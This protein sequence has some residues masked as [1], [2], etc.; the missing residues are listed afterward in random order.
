MKKD[1]IFLMPILLVDD[2]NA[3]TI[4]LKAILNNEGFD[5]ISVAS[6]VEET[7]AF[8]DEYKIDLILISTILSKGSGIELCHE[9]NGDL[10]YEDIPAIMVTADSKIETLRK[11]FENGA[12]DYIAKPINSVELIARVQAHLIRKQVL[13]ERKKSAI[14]DVLT[15]LYNRRYFDTIFDR[16]Y[17]KSKLENIPLVFFMID[18]DNFKK[19]NDNYGH[20]AGDDALQQVSHAMKAQLKRNGDYIFRLGGEEFAIL[21]LSDNI[22]HCQ[23]LSD[24]LHKG[25]YDL[26]IEHKYN[27]KHGR[28]SVSIGISKVDVSDLITKFDIYNT[29]DEALYHAK[30]SGR[31]HSEFINI[32]P[33][34]TK[35][36]KSKDGKFRLMD[37]FK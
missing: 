9:I 15:S 35:S 13:D 27:E 18:I 26:N 29:A 36:E 6:S 7:R 19:Y 23:N 37:I 31:N 4:L 8:L 24:S 12:V 1:D 14:T 28:I 20:Q 11:S 32:K 10:R 2:S 33:D 22:D 3:N 21:L 25:I 34:G 17:N 16:Q 5:L 30:E